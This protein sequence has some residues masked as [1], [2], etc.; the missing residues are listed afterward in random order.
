MALIASS[1][2][3]CRSGGRLARKEWPAK[4][5]AG[6]QQVS[7]GR[8]Y[9][10]IS[11][12]RGQKTENRGEREREEHLHL[13]AAEPAFGR[14]VQQGLAN[15]LG[16]FGHELWVADTVLHD[17]HEQF[18]LVFAIE[19]GLTNEHLVEQH[20]EC[21]PIDRFSI[22]LIEQNFRTYVVCVL[23]TIVHAHTGP[24]CKQPDTS[25]R[26]DV[27]QVERF[28]RVIERLVDVS[29]FDRPTDRSAARSAR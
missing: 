24:S 22:R 1:Q 8:C 5:A 27:R 23:P 19:R 26:F 29:I 21:P 9:A 4:C 7:G 3:L 25:Y 14:L 28:G 18:L 6:E 2:R 10:Y 20:S 12:P 11:R 15:V 13:C 16:L 17:C